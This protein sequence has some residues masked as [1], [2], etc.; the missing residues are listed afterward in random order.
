MPA[1]E[2][3]GRPFPNIK[4]QLTSHIRCI[5]LPAIKT[6]EGFFYEHAYFSAS[7]GVSYLD[8]GHARVDGR[9]AASCDV[10]NRARS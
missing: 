8:I 5:T 7:C 4:L 1:P 10:E 9:N 3:N 6:G 2:A